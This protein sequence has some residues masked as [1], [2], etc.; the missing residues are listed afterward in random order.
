MRI[1][2]PFDCIKFDGGLR[3]GGKEKSV[4]MVYSITRFQDLLGINWHFQGIN[5]N[6]NFCYVILNTVEYYL[7]HRRS[8]KEFL[9]QLST[10][11]YKADLRNVGTC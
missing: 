2:L 10:E 5:V 8:L 7:Y 11:G 6:G 9:P 1:D 3:L 4:C